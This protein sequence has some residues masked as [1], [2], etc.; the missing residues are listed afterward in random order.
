[1]MD[2]EAVVFLSKPI[3]LVTKAEYS[4]VLERGIFWKPLLRPIMRDGACFAPCLPGTAAE[5]M[6]ENE[7]NSRLRRRVE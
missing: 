4:N 3:R 7:I 2:V 1:M 6:Y 5:T